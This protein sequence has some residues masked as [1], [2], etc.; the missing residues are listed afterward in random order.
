MPVL[1]GRRLFVGRTRYRWEQTQQYAGDKD[2]MGNR[3][4]S[5]RRIHPIAFGGVNAGYSL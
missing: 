4:A 2:S 1:T 3:N 5:L